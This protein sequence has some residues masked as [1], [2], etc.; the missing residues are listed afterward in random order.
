MAFV[1]ELIIY[2][3]NSVEFSCLSV[4]IMSKN[5]ILILHFIKN[6]FGGGQILEQ[7]FRQNLQYLSV[8]YGTIRT[9]D[10]W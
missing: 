8:L 6:S 7:N 5:I 9:L 4:I 10:R 2:S 3:E 1:T